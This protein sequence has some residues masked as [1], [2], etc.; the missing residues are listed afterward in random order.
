MNYLQQFFNPR[1]RTIFLLGFA[2][3]LPLALSGTTL[4]AWFTDSGVSITTIGFLSLVGIPYVF[5]F[6]WAPFLDK[7]I[8][9]DSLGIR[10]GWIFISQ[11]IIVMILLIMSMQSPQDTPIVL[12]GLALSLAFFSA[13]QDIAFD[14]YRTDLM[15]PQERGLG[16]AFSVTG[17]RIAMLVSGGI[18]WII[19]EHISWQISFIFMAIL[20]LISMLF[21]YR[22]PQPLYLNKKP[23]TLQQ[24]ITEPFQEFIQRNKKNGVLILLFIVIYKLGD[25]FAGNL[26]TAFLL[27]GVNFTLTEVGLVTKSIGLGSTLLG[28]FLGG[29]YLFKKGLYKSLLWFGILQAI[30]NLGFVFLSLVGKKYFI[31][32]VII[33]LENLAGGMGT[34]AFVAFL[35]GLCNHRYSATQ[36]ALFSALAAVGRVYVGPLAGYGVEWYGWTSFFAITVLM[37]LP[38]LLILQI[39]RQDIE[40]LELQ[41]PN[42][43]KV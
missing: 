30:T 32:V 21:S 17:Y 6:L 22:A 39:L 42:M 38:G 31:M 26:S 11:F 40:L 8:P 34:A 33:A 7:Y 15:R 25:A 35:M 18:A 12:G 36:F 43:N 27:R 10:R 37:A 16:A 20:M 1:L 9:M 2:S 19:A 23:L 41:A 28:V 5:K 13:S 24:A 4:Q 14:A 29:I 3:G